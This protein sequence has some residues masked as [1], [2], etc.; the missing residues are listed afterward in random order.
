VIVDCAV[1]RDGVR[2]AGDRTPES[3]AAELATP[4]P[5]EPEPGGADHD[6]AEW[7]APGTPRV[8]LGGPGRPAQL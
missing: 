1:Y 4:P 3:V 2:L 5:D 7:R 6:P 8:R